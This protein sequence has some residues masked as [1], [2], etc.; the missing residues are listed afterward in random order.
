MTPRNEYSRMSA[1]TSHFINI[2]K[3]NK[4]IKN[5]VYNYPNI[6][7][8]FLNR[9]NNLSDDV[10][11]LCD[12]TQNLQK[13]NIM[14][15]KTVSRVKHEYN[16]LQKQLTECKRKLSRAENRVQQVSHCTTVSENICVICMTNPRECAYVNCGHVCACIECSE[17]MESQC[18]ICRQ[19]GNFIKLINV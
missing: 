3:N 7:N 15:E 6:L 19:N 17:R 9:Y 16:E 11:K 13:I 10:K 1:I 14:L 2:E 4:N 12:L 18:P 8:D 5:M